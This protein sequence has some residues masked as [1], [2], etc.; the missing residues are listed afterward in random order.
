MRTRRHY[1]DGVCIGIDNGDLDPRYSH[2]FSGDV[3]SISIIADSKIVPGQFLP[4]RD[5]Q[6]AEIN[7]KLDLIMQQM[8]VNPD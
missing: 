5:D 6:L 1:K 8:G 2:P 4:S 7:R 3:H